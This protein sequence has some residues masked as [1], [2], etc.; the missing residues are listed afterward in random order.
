MRLPRPLPALLSAA[1]LALPA[2]AALPPTAQRLVEFRAVINHPD[3]GMAMGGDPITRI[4]YVR[5]DLY[6]VSGARCRIDLAI[7]GVPSPPGL[8]GP[9][10][11]EVRT[12]D[13]AC[14]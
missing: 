14:N 11:F 4:D 10:Q 7:V 3:I 9:R 13:R 8:V 2:S 12:V 1:I 6:R 5:D